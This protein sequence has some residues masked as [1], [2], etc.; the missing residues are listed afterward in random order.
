[1]TFPAYNS[2]L[3]NK[4]AFEKNIEGKQTHLFIL[5][6][7]NGLQAAITNYGGNIIG[8]RVPDK[9][10]ALVDVVEGLDSIEGCESA[11]GSYYGSIIG[12]FGNRIANGKFTLDGEGYTLV[13]NDNPNT[14]HGGNPGFHEVVWD[15]EQIDETT[16]ELKYLSK[17]M[18]GGFPGNL[19]VKVTYK[20]TNDNALSIS[21]EAT[22]DKTTVL[23]LTSHP[24]FNLNGAGSGSILNHSVQIFADHF[25]PIN[26]NLIPTGVIEPVEGTSFDFI[27]PQTIGSRVNADNQQLSYGR[28]YDHNYVLNEHTYET[29]VA[30]AIG[31]KSGIEMSV[32]TDE[33]GMQFYCGNFMQGKNKMKYGNQDDFRT[34]FAMETQHY[35]DSPNQQNFPSTVLKP[36]EVYKTTSEYRFGVVN[37]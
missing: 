11:K 12:R 25:T 21:Y 10:G 9:M 37:K 32:L 7:I 34:A 33:P 8:L 27:R 5:K 35:P 22:T 15:A 31:D 23:N 4:S 18:E 20:L 28:G 24:Y 19:N 6:N 17:D 13:V 29:P 26:S 3:P 30:I 2:E 14:L 36:G 16:L 1:M